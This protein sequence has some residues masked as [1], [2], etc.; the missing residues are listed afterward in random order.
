MTNQYPG[1]E[2][3]ADELKKYFSGASGFFSIML[4]NGEIINHHPEDPKSFRAWLDQNDVIDVQLQA[5]WTI[6]ES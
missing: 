5:R 1:F 3:S 4:E 6:L 2:Y